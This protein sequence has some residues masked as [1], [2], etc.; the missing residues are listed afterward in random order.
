MPIGYDPTECR[1]GTRLPE[2]IC[3]AAREIVGLEERTG[4]DLIVSSDRLIDLDVREDNVF[5]HAAL[6]TMLVHGVLI[7]RKTGS[8]F[9]SSIPDLLDIHR[10]MREW[11]S[12]ER[13]V[14]LIT[15]LVVNSSGR[16]IADGRPTGWTLESIQGKLDW[17][18]LR[19]GWYKILPTIEEIGAWLTTILAALG[20][21]K[22]EPEIATSAVHPL[23]KLVDE[24]DNWVT[25]GQMFPRGVGRAKRESLA[26]EICPG[27]DPVNAPPPLGQV[28]LYTT[29]GRLEQAGGWGPTL[30]E[31]MRAYCGID[32]G[33]VIR[34]VPKFSSITIR[35]D[36]LPFRISGEGIT[37]EI[38]PDG[39]STLTISEY[40]ALEELVIMLSATR[41]SHGK[42]QRE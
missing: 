11:A 39:S 25:T 36:S 27:C 2:A 23:Q 22:E 7:Q 19:G 34:D 20:K 3:K 1:E 35:F 6:E 8:D 16:A 41:G 13:C 18:C 9:L 30:L 24:P 5:T 26:R 42:P 14:L 29:S 21:M 38:G 17:W 40:A 37:E 33:R 4:A 12:P 28:L 32:G 15:D 10:R 31:R